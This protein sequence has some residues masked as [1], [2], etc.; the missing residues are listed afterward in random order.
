MQQHNQWTIWRGADNTDDGSNNDAIYT[1][2]RVGETLAVGEQV[3]MVGAVSGRTKGEITQLDA[4]VTATTDRK[5]TL[6]HQ[7]MARYAAKGGDSG[8][9]VFTISSY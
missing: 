6:N 2:T 4:T 1:V 3:Y 8:A 5:V 9:P 7:M